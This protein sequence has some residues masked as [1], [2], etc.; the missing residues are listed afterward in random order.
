M[1]DDV[2]KLKDLPYLYDRAGRVCITED[3]VLRIV[4]ND[5]KIREYKEILNSDYVEGWFSSGLVYTEIQ[6]ENDGE[7][8]LQ[9]K[10]IPFIL[11][12]CEYSNEMFWRAASMILRLN[13]NLSE[14]GFLLHDA[15]PWNVSFDGESPVFYDFTSIKKSNSISKDWFEEFYSYF[16][17][18]IWLA[19][20][21]KK[22]YPFSKEYRKEH[23]NGFGLK[24]FKS[25]YIKKIIFRNFTSLVKY[26]D[27]PQK[28]LTKLI[29]WVEKHKPISKEP[30]YW[31]NYYDTH[32]LDFKNPE[33]IKQKF[34]YNILSEQKP[35][36]VLDLA[37]NKGYYAEMA[38]YLGASVMAFDYEEEIVNHLA[39][40]NDSNNK[41]TPAFMDLKFPTPSL[42]PGLFWR[43]SFYRF[44]S[45]IVLALGLIHHIC[46]SQEVP[47]YLFCE[48]CKKYA[49]D[50][51][52]LEF[53]DPSD[54]HVKTWNKKTP[55]DY[56]IESIQKFME[57]K[58]LNCKKSELDS[59]NGINRTYLYFYK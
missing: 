8:I 32:N 27:E 6:K 22:T 51:I 48:T 14:N 39:L 52:I 30:E 31:S 21:S 29:D 53:V 49:M 50:G 37:S 45:N 7:L 2:S 9:H 17:V 24:I 57:N 44:K 15:H 40:V 41:I 18:P 10:K 28:L 54:I 34:V 55:K 36:K 11:H 19:S 16:I 43:D 58:F 46:L 33:T 35:E 38:S 20:Y 13:L 42:G 56:S 59:N 47:V 1:I 25:K 3:T 12:P 5:T 4:E 26:Q 23:T